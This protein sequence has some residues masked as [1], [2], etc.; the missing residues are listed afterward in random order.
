M[1]L[2]GGIVTKYIPA[3]NAGTTPF[4]PTGTTLNSQTV[5]SAIQELAQSQGAYRVLTALGPKIVGV[6]FLNQTVIT[7]LEYEFLT[8]PIGEVLT[9]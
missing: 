4:D 6:N 1:S 8:T 5:Q 2:Y 7:Q 9:F 3:P